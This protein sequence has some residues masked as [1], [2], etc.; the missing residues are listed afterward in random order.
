MIWYRPASSVPGAKRPLLIEVG[1]CVRVPE[2][3]RLL[4]LLGGGVAAMTTV[5]SPFTGTALPQAEQKRLESG[6][7]ELHVG[8]LIILCC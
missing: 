3:L 6:S 4:V 5:M 1:K 8:Q 7:C 2:P